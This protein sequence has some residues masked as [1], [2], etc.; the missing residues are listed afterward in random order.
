M[1]LRTSRIGQYSGRE[2]FMILKLHRNMEISCLFLLS[3]LLY[4]SGRNI[5]I[6]IY[7]YFDIHRPTVEGP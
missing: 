6:E 3:L 4:S 1:R 5:K 7:R 2:Y